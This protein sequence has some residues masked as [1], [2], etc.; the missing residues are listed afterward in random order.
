M[1][2][3]ARFQSL[4]GAEYNEFNVLGLRILAGI[5][6]IQSIGLTVQPLEFQRG[7]NNNS[8]VQIPHILDHKTETTITKMRITGAWAIPE[9]RIRDL[10]PKA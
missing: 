8:G 4:S 6:R 3:R 1:Q 10:D 7:T 9:S 5:L 2:R